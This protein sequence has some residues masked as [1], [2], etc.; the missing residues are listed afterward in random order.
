VPTEI[1]VEGKRKDSCF[2]S[3]ARGFMHLATYFND[4]ISKKS[5]YI[6][7]YKGKQAYSPLILLKPM[8]HISLI[9]FAI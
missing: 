7:I 1:K 3:Y 5:I 6:Y 4:F 9:C 8:A 2:I